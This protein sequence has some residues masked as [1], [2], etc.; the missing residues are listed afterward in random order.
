MTATRADPCP[1]ASGAMSNMMS[2]RTERKGGAMTER[3]GA[4]LQALL[5]AQRTVTASGVRMNLAQSAEARADFVTEMRW[6]QGGL[7]A[8]RDRILAEFEKVTA[9]RDEALEACRKLIEANS[10]HA[11]EID[12]DI[13]A[14]AVDMAEAALAKA[15]GEA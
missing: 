5:N 4:L 11:H 13:L 10:I 15:G 12:E 14:L 3:L 7:D 6:A 2:Y 8:I 1:G 9:E